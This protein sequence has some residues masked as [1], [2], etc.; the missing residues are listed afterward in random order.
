MLVFFLC[1]LHGLHQLP[2]LR[3][4]PHPGRRQ[5]CN[6]ADMSAK[7]RIVFRSQLAKHHHWHS[8][9]D[10]S[11]ATNGNKCRSSRE[12]HR[13][14]QRPQ[15]RRQHHRGSSIIHHRSWSDA[16]DYLHSDGSPKLT[17]PKPD[18]LWEDLFDR[19]LRPCGEDADFCDL[20]KSLGSRF[21]T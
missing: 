21:I 7:S 10:E 8:H 2:L 17:L 19:K 11:G 1:S 12:L 4:G 3:E 13:R 9:R 18:E 14:L 20:P 5:S 15:Q 16:T 6:I